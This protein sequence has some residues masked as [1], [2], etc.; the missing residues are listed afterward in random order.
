M[1]ALAVVVVA[2]PR[3]AASAWRAWATGGWLAGD[4]NTRSY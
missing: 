4:L 3:V 2:P 1:L